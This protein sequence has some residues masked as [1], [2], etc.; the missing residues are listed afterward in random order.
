MFVRKSPGRLGT[1]KV[2]LAA[3]RY[4]RDVVLEHVG[5]ARDEAELAALMSVARRRMHDGQEVLD[6]DGLGLHDEGVP[7][8]PAPITSK[9]S[10]LLWQVLT[11]AYV[12]PDRPRRHESGRIADS[13]PGVVSGVSWWR[14][15]SWL[16]WWS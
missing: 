3:R 16:G 13:A 9:R 1:T 8:R 11:D 12:R 15:P 7:A 10:A 2:Q 4:G 14:V 6:L 5:T